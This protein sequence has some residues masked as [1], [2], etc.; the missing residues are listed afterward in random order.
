MELKNKRTMNKILAYACIL[1]LLSMGI[2]THA[3]A[4]VTCSL[5]DWYGHE[6]SSA[7]PSDLVYLVAAITHNKPKKIKFLTTV[8]FHSTEPNTYTVSQSF[9]GKFNHEASIETEYHRMLFWIPDSLYI[10]SVTVKAIFPGI[11][12]CIE[13]LEVR[14]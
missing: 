2:S 5:V 3:D 11:G 8:K 12:K 7:T 1:I 6:I 14:H 13:T 9:Q 4:E 10:N